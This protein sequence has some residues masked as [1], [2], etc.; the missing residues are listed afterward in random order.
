[1]RPALAPTSRRR[2]G[3]A[4]LAGH[5]EE[6]AHEGGRP[7]HLVRLR[8][9]LQQLPQLLDVRVNDV[10]EVVPEAIAWSPPTDG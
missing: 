7:A 4:R 1:M 3:K 8:R 9:Q 2:R 10:A 6:P 5:E